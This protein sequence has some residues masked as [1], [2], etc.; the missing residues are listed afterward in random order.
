MTENSYIYSREDMPETPGGRRVRHIVGEPIP[1]SRRALDI[2]DLGEKMARAA[3]TLQLFAD[4]TIGQGESFEKI[5][6]QAK[7]VYED[8]RTAS[9][10]YKP[11]G[12]ALA[13]YAT[14]L[15]AV[16]EA[17][18]GKVD[19]A[20][21]TWPDVRAA[22]WALSEAEGEQRDYD[23]TTDEDDES[24][25]PRPTTH[26]EQGAFDAAVA[27]WETYW[28]AYDAPVETWEG[29]YDRAVSSLQRTN[30][31]GVADGFWD[32]AMPFVE[33]L[34]TVLFYLG[35]ALMIVAFFVTGPLALLAGVLAVIVGVLSLMGELA[36]MAAGR[37]DWTSVALAAV[38]VIPFGKLAKLGSLADLGGFGPRVMGALRLGGDEFLRYGDDF[39]AFMRTRMPTLFNRYDEAGELIFRTP[40]GLNSQNLFRTLLTPSYLAQ[41]NQWVGSIRGGWQALAGNP[42]NV[43]E[44]FGGAADVYTDG[45]G[46]L[47]EANGRLQAAL[48]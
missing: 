23:R 5:R 28:G 8:L 17:T 45:M 13:A 24:A 18:D 46:L 42:T 38:G 39:G 14:A 6:E 3:N 48:G 20:E 37:G 2:E 15:S 43:L 41:G 32:N 11:S 22:S 35:I 1:I 40:H 25:T 4:G 27:S 31:N 34:L 7:E 44:A 33:G 29:A 26:A 30:A 47:Y 16:Q 36:K 10:R 21:R 9:E 12:S 19:G